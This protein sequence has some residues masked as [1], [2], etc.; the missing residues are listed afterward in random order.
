MVSIQRRN[1]GCGASALA[2]WQQHQAPRSPLGVGPSFRPSVTTTANEYPHEH[3]AETETTIKGS[4]AQAQ[5]DA[6]RRNAEGARAG[7]Q[8]RCATAAPEGDAGLTLEAQG[9]KTW[10]ARR[11]R[12]GLLRYVEPNDVPGVAAEHLRAAI[13]RY[14]VRQQARNHT[15]SSRKKPCMAPS[16]Q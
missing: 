1:R 3:H 14:S 16:G 4:I 13:A 6:A 10:I 11:A 7:N 5:A 8:D 9:G 2:G 15:N 12:E